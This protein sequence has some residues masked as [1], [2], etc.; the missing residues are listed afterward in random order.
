M[1]KTAIIQSQGVDTVYVID[2]NDEA[3]LR[4]VTLGPAYQQSF[5]VQSGLNA[6]DRVVT[7]GT[8]KVK[9]GAKVIVKSD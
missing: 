8:Q 3:A 4:T 7:E 5:V 1:S 2:S 6:G 9:P